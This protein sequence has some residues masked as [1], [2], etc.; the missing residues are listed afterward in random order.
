MSARPPIIII[1]YWFAPS[2]A[3]GAKRFSFLA[4]EF[5]RLGF[6]VHV[7]TN[8]G[9]EHS[10]WKTDSSLPLAGKIHRCAEPVKLPLAGKGFLQRAV[11]FLLRPVL[12]PIGWELLWARSAARKALEVARNL[13]RGVVIATSPA[14]AAL[15]AGA[16][17]AR[18]L[19][20]P[21][22]L[23]YRDPW[24]AYEWPSWRRSAAALWWAR[25]FER[26]LVKLSAARVLNTPAMRLAFG[27]F[28]PRSDPSRNFVIPNG[29]EP[30][31]ETAPPPATGPV[32]IVHAGEI[33]TGRSLV[34][35]LRAA[36]RLR[37]RFPE[38]PIR[39][40]TYGDL[41]PAEL[42]RIR[43]EN[44]VAQ[45]EV[46]PRIPFSDLFAD[47]QRA[48]LLLAVVGEHMSYSTPYKVY[49]YMA[50]G[51]PILAIAPPGAALF[52]LLAD[53]GAGTCIERDDEAG[54]ERALEKFLTGEA[55]PL[56][57]RVER[58]RW[59]NLALQYRAVI[60]TVAGGA[61]GAAAR[62]PSRL[63]NKALDQPNQ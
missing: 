39:V 58:F 57:A 18:R 44:L 22:I 40:I 27:R 52:E 2:P 23:D 12:T 20:W 33:Y 62:E 48:H 7:I 16:Q 32:H 49:D 13:P 36:A 30:V 60:D 11:N 15:L 3:V 31:A 24:S 51:R 4:R 14:H 19:D 42:A 9:R 5:T 53:S 1:S 8:E 63:T 34:P 47:L 29:F 46:R 38:R 59:S 21:L 35:V 43:A 61:A 10:D 41:P 55:T 26:P 45:I 6:D 17:V 25:R 37:E 50:A 56:R 54:I 28:F